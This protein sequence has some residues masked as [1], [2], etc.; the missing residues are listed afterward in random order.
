MRLHVLALASSYSGVYDAIHEKGFLT[1]RHENA[2][3]QQ[4]S[5]N[6]LTRAQEV[7]RLRSL[8]VAP[9]QLGKFRLKERE[10]R[11]K[12]M[13][14]LNNRILLLKYFFFCGRRLRFDMQ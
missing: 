7:H 12:V 10:D 4:V 5:F 2:S 1:T 11:A 3:P 9:V 14:V 8:F 13:L 6:S